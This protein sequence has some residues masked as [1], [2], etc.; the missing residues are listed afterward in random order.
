MSD[1]LIGSLFEQGYLKRSLKNGLITQPDIALTELVANAWDAGATL[2]KITIPSKQ[3]EKLIVEDN[4]IGMTKQ[5]FIDRWM[6]LSYDRSLHQG[7]Q[8]YSSDGSLLKRKPYGRNGVGRHGLLCFNDEYEVY[9]AKEGKEYYFQVTTKES[10]E[11]LAIVKDLVK[12]SDRIGTRLVV[13]VDRNLP[14][15]EEIRDIISSRFL[16]DPEFCIQINGIRLEIDQLQG[17]LNQKELVTSDGIRLVASFI[18]TSKAA[19]KSR[20]QGIA[21]WQNGR[22]IGTPSWYLGEYFFLDGRSSFAKRYSFVISSEDLGPYIKEDWSG[23]SKGEVRNNLYSTVS[24][25]VKSSLSDIARQNIEETKA[26]VKED[27]KDEYLQASPY[28]RIQVDEVI[29]SISLKAPTASKETVS[30]VARAVLYL[31]SSSSGKELLGKLASMGT[32]DIEALNA[33][34]SRWTVKDAMAVLSEV[35]NRLL[36]IEAITKLSKDKETDE[37]HVLHPLLTEARWL[38]GPEYDTAEYTFN[39]QVKTVLDKLFGKDKLDT[40]FNMKKRPDLVVLSNGY[41]LSVTATESM[42]SESKQFKVRDVLIVELKR[43][44]FELTY[45]EMNQVLGYASTILGELGSIVNINCYVVGDTLS[46]GLQ[47]RM[48]YGQHDEV[49]VYA[50]TYDELMAT[51]SKRMFGLRDKVSEMY[52]DVPGIELYQQYKIGF[53]G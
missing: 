30:L 12:D 33:I 10:S 23:F 13:Q 24:D 6:R 36:L 11:A 5:E 34:L 22:L 32:E 21:F 27:I 7:E 4:G 14:N 40:S 38:F 15:I 17:L 35:D 8:V 3:N 48:K 41:S 25:Y 18:D 1:T 19:R 50:V 51:A 37:L 49:K 44:G 43:G 16:L 20:F 46:K 26:A 31:Q 9:S 42:D 39:R 45:G 29:E 52:D 53:K 2:V 28:A 47:T